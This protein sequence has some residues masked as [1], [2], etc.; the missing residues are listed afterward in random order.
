MKR[1][2]FDCGTRDATASLGILALRLLTGLMMLIGHGIPKLMDYSAR[3]DLFYVPDFFP[4]N[5]MSPPLSLM[6]SISAEV[7][8]SILIILGIA[9]R[10]AAFILGFSM[11]VAVFGFHADA[12]WF[13]KPPT[14]VDAKELGLLYLIPMIAII[15][16]GGGLFSADSQLYRDAKRRRW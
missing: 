12:P 10:P 11:V 9:T 4:L 2:L 1:F 6:A 3:K 5:F 7:G 8:A 14:Y 16:S 15:F 13:V